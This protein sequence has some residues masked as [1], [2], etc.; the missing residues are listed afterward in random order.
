[1]PPGG[2][3]G[4]G[5]VEA[6]IRLVHKPEIWIIDL[7]SAMAGMLMSSS[8]LF[9]FSHEAY[10]NSRPIHTY[11]DILKNGDFFPYLKKFRVYKNTIDLRV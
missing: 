10:L 11:P 7:S 2:G 3:G 6:S 9:R 1:M 5:D 8:K 4:R